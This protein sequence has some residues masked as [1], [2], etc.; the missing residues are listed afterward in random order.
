MERR[1]ARRLSTDEKYPP[2]AM[3][4]GQGS[5]TNRC[6]RICER[7]EKLQGTLLHTG[8][9]DRSLRQPVGKIDLDQFSEKSQPTKPMARRRRHRPSVEYVRG[10][11]KELVLMMGKGSH[12]LWKSSGDA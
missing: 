11:I 1:L 2:V 6:C 4:I 10:R 3:T 7:S 12:A 8:P 5:L 9:V